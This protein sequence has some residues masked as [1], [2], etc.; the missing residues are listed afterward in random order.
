MVKITNGVS[1]FEVTK[2][3]FDGIFS[4]QGFTLVN[5]ESEDESN[6]FAV[7]GGEE[8]TEDEKFVEAVKEKPISQWSKE[9]VKRFAVINDISLSGTKSV[10]EAKEVIKEF[11]ESQE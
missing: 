7:N 2:G 9:D 3:A 4:R 10:N 1:V 8:K 6:G 11:I 5:D